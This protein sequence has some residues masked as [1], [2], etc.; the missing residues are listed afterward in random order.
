MRMFPLGSFTVTGVLEHP[1]TADRSR[2]IPFIHLSAGIGI[3]AANEPNTVYQLS[4]KGNIRMHRSDLIDL[5]S[6]VRIG[7]AGVLVYEPLL[8]TTVSGRV[9][10]EVH[11]DQYALS[12]APMGRLATLI[13]ARCALDQVNWPLVQEA[14]TRKDGIAVDV[15]K[16]VWD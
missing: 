7:T 16:T 8:A 12:H 6:R 10:V 13:F 5:H 9:F 11:A 14:F 1:G 4:T 3:E 2:P 15:T